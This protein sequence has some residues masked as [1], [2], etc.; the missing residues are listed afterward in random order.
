MKVTVLGCGAAGGVPMIS[1]G[2]GRCDPENPKNRRRRPSILVEEGGQTILIDT[3]PDLR[4]QLL[5][6]KVRHLDAVLLT[7]DHADHTHGID[8][9]R[10]VNRAM[11][12]PIPAYGTKD[13]L[14]R[15]EGRFGYVFGD[16]DL[17]TVKS[18]YKPWL[19]RQEI[20]DSFNINGLAI[21]AID[22]DHGY[23][24]TSG[25]RFGKMAYCT[26]VHDF[27]DSSLDKLTGLDV[28]IIG[29]LTEYPHP[30]H[31]HV[32]KVLEWVEKLRPKQTWITHM[33]PNL[34][35]QALC[36]QLPP[37]IRPAYDG[38]VIEI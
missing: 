3:G 37:H 8:D 36:D 28:W 12:A 11:G 10:E 23:G 29:C 34:D 26:D 22:Q 18:I 2:W 13:C 6:A 27:P 32:G 9:L 17:G 7:H 14:D 15:I 31:A 20:T 5:D 21:D 25:F 33:S 24:R 4:E 30:T 38:L 16:I 19:I 35:Y 1:V